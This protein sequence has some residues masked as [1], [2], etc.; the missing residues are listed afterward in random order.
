VNE[1]WQAFAQGEPRA[2]AAALVAVSMLLYIAGSNLAWFYRT[3][4]EGGFAGRIRSRA[5]SPYV[6]A[7]YELGRL[8]YYVGVPYVALIL[9]WVD[10]R[11]LGLG[12]LDWA[13]GLRWTIVLALATWSLL[14][15]VWV[16]YLRATSNIPVRLNSEVLSWSR[17][18]VEVIY[19]QAH[20]AFYRAACILIL[21]SFFKDD[22]AVYWGTSAGLALIFLEAWADPR[23]RRSL[24]HVGQGELALWSAGQ[25][26]INTVGF[27]LTRNVWLLALI[28]LTLEFT[29]PHLRAVPRPVPPPV[30]VRRAPIVNTRQKI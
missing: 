23:V 12:Y 10:L 2:L 8:V 22:V 15:F 20:W 17:R 30:P 26:I 11:A 6:R 3:R 29:V 19:M 25:A 18:A 1:L 21:I 9:G 14:M 28:Q 5:A 7:L 16:P 24:T 13:D 4:P 27:V